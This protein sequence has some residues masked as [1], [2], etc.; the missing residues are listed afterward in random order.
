MY[1]HRRRA[2]WCRVCTERGEP[3]LLPVV[4]REVSDERMLT[5][6]AQEN[7]QRQDLDPVEEA[8]IVAWHQQM[9]SNK[10]QAEIGAMLGKS[11]DWVSVR[12]RIHKLP[13]TLKE[14]L[15]QRPRAIGQLLELSTLYT[16]QP[17]MALALADRVVHENVTVAAL[18]ALIREARQPVPRAVN[19]EEQ[20]NRRANATSVQEITTELHAAPT[21]PPQDQ[22]SEPLNAQPAV[23][24]TID[25]QSSA[26]TDRV[27]ARGVANWPVAEIT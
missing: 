3:C 17:E 27:Q 7:L 10:N 1:G 11:S 16:Q 6:G 26:T 22:T 24:H 12:A 8:Q 21:V 23:V 2:A 4:V 25:L 9:F 20:H 13:D 5:I 18:R 15:R 14:R 19:R